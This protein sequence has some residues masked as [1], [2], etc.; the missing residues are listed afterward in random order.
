MLQELK[1]V[2]QHAGE[3]ERR[4]FS[5]REFDLIVWLDEHAAVIAFDLCYGKPQHEHVFRWRA[6]HGMKHL[7]VDDGERYGGRHKMSPIY[8]ADGT[9]DASATAARF[10]VVSGDVPA[11]IRD[12]VLRHLNEV[13]QADCA[14]AANQR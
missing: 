3:P 13:A 5:N 10:A 8:V 9:H 2:R 12:T 14:A 11:E 7:R 6:A 4:W 1:K